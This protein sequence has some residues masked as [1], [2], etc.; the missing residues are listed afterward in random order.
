MATVN[1][2]G[3]GHLYLNVNFEMKAQ[4]IRFHKLGVVKPIILAAVSETVRKL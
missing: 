3:W 2:G 1:G 4:E